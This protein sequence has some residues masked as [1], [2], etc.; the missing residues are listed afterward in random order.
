MRLLRIIAIALALSSCW[1]G[2]SLYADADARA[3]V[4]PGAY[5]SID[6]QGTIRD[7][8]VSILPN[9]LTQFDS[10]DSRKT[11]GFAPL[12]PDR[13]T[14]V[15]WVNYEANGNGD[16]QMYALMV[17]QPDGSFAIYAPDCVGDQAEIARKSGATIQPSTSSA[18]R[19]PT[20]ASLEDA[21]RRLHPTG[22]P[23]R[24]VRIR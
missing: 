12:D 11:Y 14:F 9:G 19:F 23:V 24:L 15:A 21:M 7:Y 2:R 17:T 6:P 4:A 13:G 22:V 5:Q 18:C 8:R 10:R 1:A 20:R 3:A 16:N